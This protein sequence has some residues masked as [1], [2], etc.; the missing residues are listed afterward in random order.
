MKKRLGML[1]RAKTVGA[2]TGAQG[3]LCDEHERAARREKAARRAE[4]E[5]Q[6]REDAEAAARMAKARPVSAVQRTLLSTLRAKSKWK[7]A[8]KAA[9][10]GL[11]S[12]F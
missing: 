10:G 4:A 6:A 12:G 7:S 11:R 5:Q 9:S 8:S 3:R 2:L 1:R